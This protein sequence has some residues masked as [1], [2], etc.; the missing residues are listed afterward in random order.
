MDELGF[1]KFYE[2]PRFEPIKQ[3][4]SEENTFTNWRDAKSNEKWLRSVEYGEGFEEGEATGAAASVL[5]EQ[6]R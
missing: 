4:D 5:N 2:M 3:G 1:A 6:R